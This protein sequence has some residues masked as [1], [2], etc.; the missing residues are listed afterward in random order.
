MHAVK[1]VFVVQVLFWLTVAIMFG[2]AKLL[3]E[4]PDMPMTFISGGMT[5]AGW[6]LH[7]ITEHS[8]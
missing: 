4:K 1:S 2:M 5:V 8:Q 6:I 7:K 3:G